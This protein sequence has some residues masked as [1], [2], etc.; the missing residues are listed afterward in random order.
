MLI[1]ILKFK[2][3]ITNFIIAIFLYGGVMSLAGLLTIGERK[4]SALIQDR[5]GPNRASILGFRFW[6]LFHPLADGIKMIMKE[7]FIPRSANKILFTIAPIITVFTIL[8]VFAFIPFGPDITIKDIT[9]KLQ[10]ADLNLSIFLLVAIS[11]FAIYGTLLAGF[12]SKN[13]WG[14]LGSMRACALMLS[15]EVILLLSLL[16]LLMIYNASTFNDVIKSQSNNLLGFIPKWGIFLNPI[17][18]VL[19]FAAALCENKRTP[20]DVVEGESEIIGYFVEYGSMRFAAFMFAEYIEIILFSMLITIFFFGGWNIPY[21]SSV[22]LNTSFLSPELNYYLLKIMEIISFGL[23]TLFFCFIIIFTRWTVPRFR[24][25]QIIN[26]A[27]KY[28][29]PLS[30][31]NI[32]L[33]AVILRISK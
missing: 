1:E 28:I 12:G 16:P 22:G 27:W 2:D 29:M 30:L 15:Y 18:F 17:C 8:F 19:F 32:I 25:D 14:V 3:Y 23:K 10:I 4:I 5:I 33:T 7:D 31:I 24:F 26:L 20:F 13:S 11:S 21:I 6:G 9:I